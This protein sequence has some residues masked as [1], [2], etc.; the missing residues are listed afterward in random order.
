MTFS[1]CCCP[2]VY[3]YIYHYTRTNLPKHFPE[4]FNNIRNKRETNKKRRRGKSSITSLQ[5]GRRRLARG[6]G[7]KIWKTTFTS[8]APPR[9]S[10]CGGDIMREEPRESNNTNWT[11]VFFSH[12]FLVPVRPATT[13]PRRYTTCTTATTLLLPRAWWC[14]LRGCQMRLPLRQ[15]RFTA[16]RRCEW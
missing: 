16:R 10:S 13:V 9:R 5:P 11:D 3:V 2:C 14:V 7:N 12:S 6:E 8:R 15:F 1:I 4:T